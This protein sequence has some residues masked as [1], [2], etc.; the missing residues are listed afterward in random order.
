MTAPTQGYQEDQMTLKVAN[1]VTIEIDMSL[2]LPP[3][4]CPRGYAQ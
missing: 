1:N 2:W 3:P 4:I